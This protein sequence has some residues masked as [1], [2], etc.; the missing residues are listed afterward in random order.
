MLH[1]IEPFGKQARPIKQLLIKGAHHGE[2]LARKLAALHADDVEAF[3]HRILA[4]HQA[5]RY[6]VAAHA[7]DTADHHLRPD[8]RMLMHRGQPADENK[9]ADLAMTAQGRGGRKNHVIADLAIVTDMTAVH[10]V[11]AVADAGDAAAGH[12]AGIHGDL[13]AD[14]AAL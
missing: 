1:A 2:P 4:V 8:A 5:E 3:E 11:A 12:G 7:A 10:E 14:N 6:H 13:L 9:I